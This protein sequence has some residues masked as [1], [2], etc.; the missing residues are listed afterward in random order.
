MLESEDD[1]IKLE[2]CAC[3]QH[4]DRSAGTYLGRPVACQPGSQRGRSACPLTIFFLP[5]QAENKY[6]PQ[7][8]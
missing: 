6:L 4:R 2:L 5:G 7:Q 3:G 1:L 8:R